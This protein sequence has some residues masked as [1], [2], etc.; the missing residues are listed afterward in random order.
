M[1]SE[2]EQEIQALKAGKVSSSFEL[3][4]YVLAS[5]LDGKKPVVSAYYAYVFVL[6]THPQFLEVVEELKVDLATELAEIEKLGEIRKQIALS[7]LSFRK[8]RVSDDFSV[9]LVYLCM[10]NKTRRIIIFTNVVY[11]SRFFLLFLLFVGYEQ[12]DSD[13]LKERLIEEITEVRRRVEALSK[14]FVLPGFL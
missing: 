9:S 13:L 14:T 11:M 8:Q 4:L 3:F 6:G 1:D 5:G 12:R 7:N 10:H 2:V